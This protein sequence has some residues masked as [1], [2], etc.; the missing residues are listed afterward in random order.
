M[1]SIL[2]ALL[3]C[4]FVTLTWTNRVYV[5]SRWPY[6]KERMKRGLAEAI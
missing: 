2:H 4:D 3:Q 1:L 5:F 6:K